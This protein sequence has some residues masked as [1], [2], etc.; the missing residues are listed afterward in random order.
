MLYSNDRNDV[1]D[2]AKDGVI[3]VSS[4]F[5]T[6]EFEMDY[7]E[8]QEA[9]LD[10]MNSRWTTTTR[11]RSLRRT[12]LHLGVAALEPLSLSCSEKMKACTWNTT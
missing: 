8:K 12:G 9:A 6:D 2:A 7:I 1:E 4:S 5:G 3:P 11:M 10:P